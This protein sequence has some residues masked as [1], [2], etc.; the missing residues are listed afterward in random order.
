MLELVL[1]SPI[2]PYS[3][4]K[5]LSIEIAQSQEDDANGEGSNHD[6]NDSDFQ[7][8]NTIRICCGWDESLSDGILTYQIHEKNA[9]S[10][11]I[12][13]VRDAIDEWD[14]K[15]ARLQFFEIRQE[16]YSFKHPTEAD[17]HIKFIDGDFEGKIAGNTKTH[18]NNYGFIDSGSIVLSKGAL[19]KQ[20]DRQTIEVIAK[21]EIGHALGLLHAN[22]KGNLMAEKID[23]AE[24]I[25]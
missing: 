5:F 25:L 9:D 12:D 17:I 13:S 21:H 8:R 1:S 18:I 20:F 2:Q 24:D 4:P 16:E 15:L 11:L 14:G 6:N 23:G 3:L 7:E 22:F 19:G 10:D